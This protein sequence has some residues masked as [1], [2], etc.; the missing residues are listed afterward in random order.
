MSRNSFRINRLPTLAKI[1]A[2][3]HPP[4]RFL[5]PTVAHHSPV[6]PLESAFTPNSPIS[7]LESAFT[8][9]HPGGGVSATLRRPDPNELGFALQARS[10]T[11]LGLPVSNICPQPG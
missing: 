8:E 9:K 11:S 3:R 6:T 4:P 10:G 7:P 2:G 5:P 1:T